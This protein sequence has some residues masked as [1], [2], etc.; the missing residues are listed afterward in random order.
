MAMI[1]FNKYTFQYESID[2]PILDH[3]SFSLDT[4]WKCGMIG[5]NGCGKTTL[6]KILA[7]ELEG[8]G[9]LIQ[10]VSAEIFPCQRIDPAL[11]TIELLEEISGAQ[12]WQIEKECAKLHLRNDI[13]WHPFETLSYGERMRCMLGAMFLKEGA[14]ILLDEPSNHL[15][16]EG[17]KLLAQYL[18]SKEGFLLVSHDRA[19]LDA[20]IDHLVVIDHEITVRQGNYSAWQI[21]H[22]HKLARDRA[23]NIRLQ[24][25]IKRLSSSARLNSEWS[26]SKEKEKIGAA[27]KG[28]IGHK[29][30]KLMKR[31]KTIEARKEKA[32]AQK[33]KL[34]KSDIKL[35]QL[36]IKTIPYKRAKLI[37]FLNV[38]VLYDSW[39]TNKVSFSIEQGAHVL[40]AGPN[41]SGKSSMLKAILGKVE[42]TGELDLASG[43]K[44][45]YV[46]QSL[47]EVKGSLRNYIEQYAIDRTKIMT[48]L[49][50][51][52]FSREE[53]ANPLL[54]LSNGQ[55]RKIMLARSLCEE[56]H[57]YI[58]DEPLNDLDLQ[59]RVQIEQ[60]LQESQYTLL[61][62]EHD[63]LFCQNIATKRVVLKND[64]A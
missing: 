63:A 32:I 50:K 45:S 54:E 27:D 52:G 8:R 24:K 40:L 29:A 59:S 26:H 23:E 7:R 55:K 44:I 37:S 16:L 6:L 46:A 47:E 36:Q 12:A 15:D 10:P 13:L 28:F 9:T 33:Q 61:F 2:D 22:E 64:P 31:S 1:T 14:Y 60:M 58:W 25:E 11:L 5:A 4:R 56:A 53:L 51:L 57:L 20:C 17:K 30:A 41:G 39:Q 18:S 49:R 35:E 42:Y 62:V 3:I 19:L 48:L 21:D 43:L 34:L 38:S